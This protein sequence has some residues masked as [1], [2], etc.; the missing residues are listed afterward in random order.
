MGKIFNIS[1]GSYVRFG[2]EFPFYSGEIFVADCGKAVG[3]CRAWDEITNEEILRCI[4]GI[5]EHDDITGE[6]GLCF[7]M[8][9][10]HDYHSPIVYVQT[11]TNKPDS[12]CKFESKDPKCEELDLKKKIDSCPSIVLKETNKN[13]ERE[14]KGI[15]T[16]YH[17][18]YK[19][20]KL[21]ALLKEC[22][23][24]YCAKLLEELS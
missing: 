10:A 13:V 4:G 8:Y 19:N 2:R 1:G 20:T 11:D 23:E 3:Y 6:T 15:I 22:E 7:I 14:A 5:L 18:S 24:I 21:N 9:A 17:E 16:Q 12:C